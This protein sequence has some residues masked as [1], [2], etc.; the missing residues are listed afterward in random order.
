M[1]STPDKVFTVATPDDDRKHDGSLPAVLLFTSLS[2]SSEILDDATKHLI[3]HDPLL[4][5]LV[6]GGVILTPTTFTNYDEDAHN[7]WALYTDVG[8]TVLEQL[9][10]ADK[11]TTLLVYVPEQGV[12]EINFHEIYYDCLLPQKSILGCRRCYYDD[13]ESP[14]DCVIKKMRG[15]DI[16]AEEFA[17]ELTNRETQIGGFTYISPRLTLASDFGK[18]FRPYDEHDFTTIEHNSE[19]ISKG[20]KERARFRKFQKTACNQCFVENTCQDQRARDTRRWC[21]GPFP[22]TAGDAVM[23]V[24]RKV[25]I[26][27]TDDE[28]A[29]LLEN[30]YELS[31]RYMRRKYWTTFGIERIMNNTVLRFGIQRH[32]L[33]WAPMEFFRS[34]AEAKAFILEYGEDRNTDHWTFPL[35]PE[36]KAVLIELAAFDRSPV[37]RNRWRHTTYPKVAVTHR[38]GNKLE[39]KFYMEGQ[40]R[41]AWFSASAETL[42]DVYSDWETFNFISQQYHANRKTYG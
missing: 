19:Q 39:A 26:P 11:D 32:T 25:H 36:L 34:F 37:H 35:D 27:Y 15:A 20:I 5:K 28:L 13:N 42:E 10:N 6:E 4:R 31:K 21:Q 29:Y 9:E 18:T 22:K 1:L 38:Y 41:I 7:G 30:S 40:R 12:Q 17:A 23:E 3:L 33:P 14:K 8:D 2:Y 16:S 24:L